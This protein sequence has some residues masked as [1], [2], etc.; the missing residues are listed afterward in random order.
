M[1]KL[2]VIGCGGYVSGP[3]V[4]CA[5]R[6]GIKTALHEQNAFPGVTNKLLAKL[7]DGKA[8]F[9]ANPGKALLSEDGASPRQDFMRDTVHPN[10]KGYEVLG[11]ELGILL[12][13][14]DSAYRGGQD[15]R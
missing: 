11:R 3:V 2:L 8:V 10:G 14:M 7:H 1:A 12:K 9:F 13:R 15:S 5:A 4:R 6:Q